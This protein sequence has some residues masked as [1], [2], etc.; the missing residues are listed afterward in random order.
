MNTTLSQRFYALFISVFALFAGFGL[1]LNSAGVKLSQMGVNSLAIGALNAAFFAG[2][3]LSA[4]GAHRIVSNVGHIRSF[5]VFGAVF[6]MCSLAHLMTENLYAWG[7]L[8]TILGFC[9][10]SM[11]MVVE[12]WFTEQ[13][14]QEQRAKVL[15]IYNLVY[16]LAFTL[17]IVLLSLNLSSNNI[18]VLG[19][20]LVIA[21]MVPVSL[22]RMRAPEVP[23]RQSINVPR[24]FAI[25]PLAFITAFCAGLLVNGLFTMASVF[26]LQQQFS[27]QQI[28]AFLTA[29]MIGGFLIQL[30][31]AKLSDRIG[32]RNA[33]LLCS[34]L[35]SLTSAIALILMLLGT[36]NT[37]TH[38][39]VAFV[40]GCSLFTLY[41]L[42]ITRANDRLPNNMNTV[43]VSRSLLFCYGLGSLVAPV[44]LGAVT[45][46]APQYGFYGFYFI[47]ATLLAIFAYTQSPV[48]QEERSVFVHV[49]TVSGSMAA[50][51]DPRNEEEHDKF[52]E[53]IASEHAAQLD[54]QIQENLQQP[55]NMVASPAELETTDETVP[56][57]EHLPDDKPTIEPA[58][59]A[60]EMA[61]TSDDTSSANEQ[62]LPDHK[63]PKP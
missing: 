26:L 22:T 3:S 57:D 16:Y 30:P 31:M 13:S 27:L 1:F 25:A 54:E 59:T 60:T 8:R 9:Y 62:T 19:T 39:I 46:F 2:A 45:D 12:S 48:P 61:H 6:A 21:A 17:G 35:A 14:T 42:S 40:F 11:L 20:L 18:F 47:I 53:T 51:L 23:P 44:I 4:I 36:A 29:S 41:A 7:V 56:N 5:S 10:F 34:I 58:E 52:D 49:P 50:E 38:N 32:R 43:E 63:Q 24:I 55:E 28:S 37:M 15:A 33:I